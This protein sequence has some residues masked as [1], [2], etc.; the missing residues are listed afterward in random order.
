[1]FLGVK[2]L[3]TDMWGIGDLIGGKSSEKTLV[4]SAGGA[5]VDRAERRWI[6]R[7]DGASES[8]Q[9][10]WRCDDEHIARAISARGASARSAAAASIGRHLRKSVGLQRQ[11][12]VGVDGTATAE[13][14][15]RKQALSSRSNIAASAAASTA[16][17]P[18]RDI[19]GGCTGGYYGGRNFPF[20]IPIVL[21]QCF[22]H[23]HSG[24]I[25]DEF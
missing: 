6:E 3:L 19:R 15:L 12:A 18:P 23:F 7:S 25:L 8:W 4:F 1:M 10:G 24:R 14:R 9:L 13:A 17:A 2:P 5:T 22:H 11:Q 21:D 16:L 20:S